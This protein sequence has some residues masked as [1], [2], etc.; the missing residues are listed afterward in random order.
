MAVKEETYI[1]FRVDAETG[2]PHTLAHLAETP[3][4]EP[5]VYQFEN[6]DKL[7]GG[8]DGIDNLPILEL[9]NR[10]LYLYNRLKKL[11]ELTR[12]D[13]I[14]TTSFSAEQPTDGSF[15]VKPVEGELS[16]TANASAR[17]V[18]ENGPALVDALAHIVREDGAYLLTRTNWGDAYPGEVTGDPEDEPVTDAD[19]DKLF[20]TT[21]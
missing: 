14:H 17:I 13:D 11:G 3:S 10:T 12:L 1:G 4:W 15:W 21:M 16:C 9:A 5:R 18:P 7:I 8:P 20:T 6:G 2:K 19:I